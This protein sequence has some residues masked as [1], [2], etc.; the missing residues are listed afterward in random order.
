MGHWNWEELL[1]QLVFSCAMV[2]AF[3]ISMLSC[4]PRS[5]FSTKVLYSTKQDLN[6]E[7]DC[8]L[9][10]GPQLGKYGCG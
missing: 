6:P 8:A 7:L 10:A 9:N 4:N 2:Q 1:H 3:L 5:T